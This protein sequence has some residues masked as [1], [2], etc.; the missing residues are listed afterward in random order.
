MY[1][2]TK[3]EINKLIKSSKLADDCFKY[4]CKNIEI[5]M[6]EKQIA[7]KMDTYMLTHGATSLAFDTIVGSGPKSSQIH[8]KPGTRKIADGDIIQL[9]FGCIVDGYCS[10][11][12]RVLF[13]NRVLPEYKKIYDIVLKAHSMC[14]KMTKPNMKASD[15]DLTAR[16]YIKSFGYDFKHALGHGVGKE[17]HEAP[18]VS[19]KNTKE[20]IK[21]NVVFTIEPGIYIKGKFG[22]RIEDTVVMENG[23]VVSLN[24]TSKNITIIKC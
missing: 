1:T 3:D 2:K 10:D 24:H 12:S 6:T 21:N 9:D 13:I 16:E 23:K 8:S 18:I 20:K 19:P 22:I 14:A 17:V 7:K 5:G 4:I 11:T 15:V